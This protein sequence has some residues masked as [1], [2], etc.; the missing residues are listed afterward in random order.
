MPV[1]GVQ[2]RVLF[3]ALEK[4]DNRKIVNLFCF[5]LGGRNPERDIVMK[6]YA[7]DLRGPLPN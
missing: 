1:Y 5:A 3:W 7:M 4:V 2:V 6:S